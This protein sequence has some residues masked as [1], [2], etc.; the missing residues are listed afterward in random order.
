MRR[1]HV[2]S[3]L[4]LK[5]NGIR[6]VA[7]CL[8]FL[9]AA[10][11]LQFRP[12]IPKTWDE[13]AL[14]EFELPLAGLGR[15]PTHVSPDYY[16]RIPVTAIPKTYPVYSPDREPPGY[17]TWLKR[18]EPQSAIDFQS[19]KTKDDWIR[20]GELVFNAPFRVAEGVST[21]DLRHFSGGALYPKTARD[22]TY[23]Y[24]RYWVA[25]KGDVRAFFTVCGS[26]H[27][28]VLDD[29]TVVPGAQGNMNERVFHAEDLAS[30]R[31][32]LASWLTRMKQNSTVP[33]RRPDPADVNPSFSREQAIAVEQSIVPGTFIRTGTNPLFPP[34]MPDLIGVENRRYLDA[35]GL[36]QHRSIGDLMRYAALVDGMEQLSSYE[37][38][39]PFGSLPDPKTIVRH[40]DEALYA[41]ALYIY[42]L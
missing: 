40:S 34:K 28:R 23:P 13:Q 32:D 31:A 24:V 20:A 35:T 16:Y 27:T 10:A 39:R 6:V 30:G 9:P 41:L 14:K 5:M 1:S 38:F 2:A 7:I 37:G 11:S 33:W 42:S 12:Q 19:L 25:K 4:D 21:E 36:V 3:N 8:L 29:G 17:L 18:Q 26:C 22:G 15:S